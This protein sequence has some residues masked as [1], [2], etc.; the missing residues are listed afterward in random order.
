MKQGRTLIAFCCGLLFFSCTFLSCNQASETS[1]EKPSESNEEIS[2]LSN[3][4][5]YTPPIVVPSEPLHI[6]TSHTSFQWIRSISPDLDMYVRAQPENATLYTPN[7]SSLY[8]LTNSA[9]LKT[10]ELG[11]KDWSVGYWRDHEV[12]RD[13]F[14][15]G[16]R[17][18]H[19]QFTPEG[20]VVLAGVANSNELS[21]PTSWQPEVLSTSGRGK[22]VSFDGF[23]ACYSPQGE[24]LWSTY[25]GGSNYE[26]IHSLSVLNDGIYLFGW[27]DSPDLFDRLN[28]DIDRSKKLLLMKFSFSGEMLWAKTYLPPYSDEEGHIYIQEIQHTDAGFVVL[29]CANNATLPL[30]RMNKNTFQQNFQEENYK[31]PHC[32]PTDDYYILYI[33]LEGTVSWSTYLGGSSDEYTGTGTESPKH[34]TPKIIIGET[35]FC[36]VGETTSLD[37]PLK[38]PLQ[39]RVYSGEKPLSEVWLHTG[40]PPGCPVITCFSFSGEMLWSTYFGGP[41]LELTDACMKNGQVYLSGIIQEPVLPMVSSEMIFDGYHKEAD[42]ILAQID[43]NGKLLWSTY[44][45]G[46]NW[47][48][49]DA[50]TIENDTIYFSG[51][52]GSICFRSEPEK[53]SANEVPDEYYFAMY[54]ASVIP[55][56]LDCN[57]QL[58]EV[59]NETFLKDPDALLTSPEIATEED[60][61]KHFYMSNQTYDIRFFHN[62]LYTIGVL[63]LYDY[64]PDYYQYFKEYEEMPPEAKG[65]FF[66]TRWDLE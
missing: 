65:I 22:Y 46:D 44:F 11:D 6:V 21:S 42:G 1:L 53:S 23:L 30:V 40:R 18:E 61:N 35:A 2:Y 20:N 27:S 37:Y 56:S 66:L 43:S 31:G 58:Y 17:F 47:D 32:R 64:V 10:N 13:G 60:S 62:K 28:S 41:P 9:L 24:R 57:V 63:K 29:C 8:A 52:T 19:L 16:I 36:I 4:P 55:N 33:D 59:Q 39:D 14:L 54:V 34:N 5:T 12:L 7:Q 38:N 26:G 15:D 3:I 25:I 51:T 50:L 49:I 45:G 48:S